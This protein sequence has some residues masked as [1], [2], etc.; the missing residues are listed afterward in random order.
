MG[1]RRSTDFWWYSNV[2]KQLE[3][4]QELQAVNRMNRPA[5]SRHIIAL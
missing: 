1:Y 3:Y 2:A 5:F 4:Y